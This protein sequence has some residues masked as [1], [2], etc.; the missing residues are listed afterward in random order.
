MLEPVPS[1]IV[2]IEPVLTTVHAMRGPERVTVFPERV[3]RHVHVIQELPIVIVT[4]GQVPRNAIV[5]CE[6]YRV[7]VNPEL[8][9]MHVFVTIGRVAT[10]FPDPGLVVALVIPEPVA[11][12]FPER[13]VLIAC[14]MP[15]PV[16]TA[17]P[18]RAHLIVY[19]I[20]G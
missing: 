1:A 3:L 9:A 17:N 20:I 5:T 15:E 7:I 19:A 18:E 11:T 16:A 4:I 14:A 2:K 6:Q 8:R 10:A 13:R 12:V